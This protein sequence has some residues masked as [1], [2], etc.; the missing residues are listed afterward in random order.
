M[1][2][3]ASMQ[4]DRPAGTSW[5]LPGG[6]SVDVSTAK[7]QDQS[8]G[9]EYKYNIISACSGFVFVTMLTTCAATDFF[10][11]FE[12]Q[13]GGENFVR[14]DAPV[15]QP[16]GNSAAAL[17]KQEAKADE[18]EE[19]DINDF[20]DEFEKTTRGEDFRRGDA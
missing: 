6:S 9:G 18:E 4:K 12:Q 20:F 19:D 7:N 8:D 2:I 3:V 16:R 14:E 5:I 10:D 11:Q 1:Q 15:T 13:T 17:G